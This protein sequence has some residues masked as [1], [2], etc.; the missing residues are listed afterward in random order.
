MKNSK[1]WNKGAEE[2]TEITISHIAQER[3]TQISVMLTFKS[4]TAID[5][6]N[7]MEKGQCFLETS[8]F[9]KDTDCC[10]E[11]TQRDVRTIKFHWT[12]TK[13]RTKAA[14]TSAKCVWNLASLVP[15]TTNHSSSTVN[16]TTTTSLSLTCPGIRNETKELRAPSEI[17]T[18]NFMTIGTPIQDQT[19]GVRLCV[20]P[21]TIARC[22]LQRTV[23]AL[24][25]SWP[26]KTSLRCPPSLTSSLPLRGMCAIT[27]GWAT[28]MVK[29]TSSLS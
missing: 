7:N 27:M 22:G 8:S 4:S 14:T 11:E 29:K 5:R 16:L 10:L 13:C 17:V 20:S 28:I 3:C 26:T 12:W 18:S 1:L 21:P 24:T 19:T 9:T 15:I 25:T 6:T 23:W 2:K